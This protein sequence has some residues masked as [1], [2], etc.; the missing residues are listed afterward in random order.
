VE[1]SPRFGFRTVSDRDDLQMG[2]EVTESIEEIEQE[3]LTLQC[4]MTFTCLSHV[5]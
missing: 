5:W 1:E 3:G 4:C 2:V